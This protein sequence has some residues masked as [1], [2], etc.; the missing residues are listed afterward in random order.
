MAPDIEA[1]IGRFFQFFEPLGHENPLR[2]SILAHEESG[3]DVSQAHL[4]LSPQDLEALVNVIHPESPPSSSST[5]FGQNGKG[6][7]ASSI[8]GSSTLTSVSVDHSSAI[9]FSAAPSISG[10]SM[11]SNTMLSEALFVDSQIKDRPASPLQNVDG[12]SCKPLREEVIEDLGPQL[13][14][15]CD[16]LSSMVETE[17]VSRAKPFADQW[18]IVYISKNGKELSS[19]PMEVNVELWKPSTVG[20]ICELQFDRYGK[21]YTALREAVIRLMDDRATY[22]YISG[23]LEISEI[24][25]GRSENSPLPLEALFKGAIARSQSRFEFSNAHLWWESLQI[26]RHI[27][28]TSSRMATYEALIH[29]IASDLRVRIH[30]YT[31]TQEHIG[32]WLKS[33]DTIVR[34]QQ[35]VLD[36]MSIERNA[37]R[38][39]MWYVSDVRH[40]STYEDALHVTRALRAMASPA[41]PKQPGSI[42]N[43]ARHRL[44]NATAHDKSESQI[45]EALS[46]QRDYGG[47][48]KLTDEQVELTSRWLTRNSIENFC[49]GEERIH[50]F[51]FEVQK[52][53]N[54]L[55]GVSL[56]ESPVLW[57]SRLFGREKSTY[58]GHPYPGSRDVGSNIGSTLWGHGSFQSPSVNPP[59]STTTFQN[60]KTNELTNNISRLW[61]APRASAY[62]LIGADS[63]GFPKPQDPVLAGQSFT[64]GHTGY[65]PDIPLPSQFSATLGSTRNNDYTNSHGITAESPSSKR[66]AFAQQ[67]KRAL[68]S[69]LL[70]DL[71]YLLWAQGSET[72]AWVNLDSPCCVDSSPKDSLPIHSELANSGIRAEEASEATGLNVPYLHER[73]QPAPSSPHCH[74]PIQT[75]NERNDSFV[76]GEHLDNS[77]GEGY[78]EYLFPYLETYKKLLEKFSADP[79]P[80]TKLEILYELEVLAL[81]AMKHVSLLTHAQDSGPASSSKAPFLSHRTGAR[82]ISVPRTK[83]TSLEEV[84]ANCFERRAG[85][86]KF[87]SPKRGL[88]PNTAGFRNPGNTILNTDDIVNALLSIFRNANL[89]PQ[90]LFRDL[91]FIAA[92]VPPEILDKTARGKAFWDA[93][94]AALALKE[95]L[96]D[97][98]IDR[99]HQITSYHLS[100]SKRPVY[101]PHVPQ[102][103]GTTTL[104]DAAQL[105]IITAKEGSPTA[106]RELGL[107]YLTH[108]EILSRVTLPFSKSKEVFRST[109]SNDRS[110][111]DSGGLDPLTFAVVFHWMELAAN[112]GDKDAKDF[113]RG[114]G[115]LSAVM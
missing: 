38:L 81:N 52:C 26:L 78:Q 82:T 11:T 109:I 59:A 71:G 85:T 27:L 50:R 90:T 42:T 12:A 16:E 31:R 68:N 100:T 40:S 5:N 62:D 108:P 47:P 15:I 113:L 104:N 98:M 101:D 99:A 95:D 19:I 72:D 107:F 65:S 75:A 58:D 9:A 60:L 110:S 112:G 114:N 1:S 56:L 6:S 64:M 67:I 83:A 23:S 10:T 7:S 34:R 89:R 55:V 106:A 39:K 46:A 103:L 94:L 44:R 4:M 79:D 80:Y 91:Q 111:A 97:S 84:I 76:A 37:L 3:K 36:R 48:S 66:K 87:N 29:L 88:P 70:S 49:K 22:E 102:H 43:W 74:S 77:V 25:S 73:P 33:M 28:T 96:C 35:Q 32:N 18:A 92:F 86:L 30:A 115:E 69:L 105:W 20:E 45:L 93:G 24:G 61:N 13:R 2:S 21:D 54:R 53:V 41:R 14:S 51:C 8:A 17:K 63:F 57:S